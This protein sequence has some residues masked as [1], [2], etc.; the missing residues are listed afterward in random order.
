LRAYDE[1]RQKQNLA[2]YEFASEQVNANRGGSDFYDH[3]A[4][5]FDRG[6][7]N[8]IAAHIAFAVPN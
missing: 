1:S 5:V 2:A 8:R 6:I 7:R 4:R 3:V